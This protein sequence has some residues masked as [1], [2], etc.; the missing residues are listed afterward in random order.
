MRGVGGM[1]EHCEAGCGT[2]E[3]GHCGKIKVKKQ[4]ISM[5]LFSHIS[6]S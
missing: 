3:D 6:S 1:G 5:I 4:S 2:E